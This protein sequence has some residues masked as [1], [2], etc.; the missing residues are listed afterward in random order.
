VELAIAPAVGEATLVLSGAANGLTPGMLGDDD[1]LHVVLTDDARTTL[2]DTR[3]LRSL[4]LSRSAKLDLHGDSRQ[5]LRLDGISITHDGRLDLWE[6]TLIVAATPETREAMLSYLS[7]LVRD[8]RITSEAVVTRPHHTMVVTR[9]PGLT[10]HNGVPVG[11]DDLLV[12]ATWQG[13]ANLDGRVNADDYFRIDSAF[14]SRPPTPMW[15]QGDFNGDHRID[16]DDYFLIDSAFLAQ[17][18]VSQQIASTPSIATESSSGLVTSDEAPA[19][20]KRN[21]MARATPVVEI[22]RARAHSPRVGGAR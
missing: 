10:M 14:L 19:K 8:G 11:P 13:D 4:E 9:N 15:G 20:E 5:V 7:G 1:R 12:R 21:R 16:A 3:R 6:G 2:P 17:M 22:R 18:P